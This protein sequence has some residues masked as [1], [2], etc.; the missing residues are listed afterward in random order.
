MEQM[1]ERIT[2]WGIQCRTCGENILL[3]T[4]DDPRYGDF[5][6][7]LRPGS[8]QCVKG[9]VHNYD[10]DDLYFMASSSVTPATEAEILK[11]RANY[12]LL[13]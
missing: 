9:H 7:F 5:F 3:G 6:K 4:K 2:P 1:A 8:F 13:D 11:N 10:S 12:E